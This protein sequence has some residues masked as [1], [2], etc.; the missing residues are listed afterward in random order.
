MNIN[1]K[2]TNT[3]LTP[4]IKKDIQDKMAKLSKFLR[5]EDKIH[6]EVEVEKKHKSGLV[7][8]AEITIRPHGHYA[9]ARGV[10]FYAALDLAIP[11]ILE[12]LAKK[13]DKMV[14]ERRRRTKI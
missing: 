7:Q 5:P 4:A 6:V 8:R 10:D 9:E 11:K 3:T 14:S 13:K 12:Q 1:I 2:A